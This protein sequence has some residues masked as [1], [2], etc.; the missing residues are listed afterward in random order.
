MRELASIKWKIVDVILSYCPNDWL[1]EAHGQTSFKENARPVASNVND[2]KSGRGYFRHYTIIDLLGA[3]V[4]VYAVRAVP[5]ALDTW[6]KTRFIC[7][8]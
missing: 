2:N 5:S 8:L 7:D 6:T 3:R 4:Q 1:P